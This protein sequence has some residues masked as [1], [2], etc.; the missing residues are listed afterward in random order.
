MNASKILENYFWI[1]LV[2][3]LDCKDKS[4]MDYAVGRGNTTI[5]KILE[6]NQ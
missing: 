6:L 4:P 1:E 5:V 3:V 2:D